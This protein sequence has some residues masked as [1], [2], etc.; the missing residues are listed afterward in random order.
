MTDT[1]SLAIPPAPE[2]V[3]VARLFGAGLV[4]HYGCDEDRVEDVKLAISEACSSAIS[5]HAAHAPDVPVRVAV[6]ADPE[7]L[8][9]EVTGVAGLE[10]PD[11]PD[12]EMTPASGLYEGALG[13]SLIRS[14]FPKVLIEPSPEG[15]TTV[16][17]ELDLRAVALPD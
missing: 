11:D 15:G 14:L 16:A 12:D 2:Y 10:A 6:T 4:R 7:R 17:F 8:R 3:G 9:F 1:F 5:A 13:A